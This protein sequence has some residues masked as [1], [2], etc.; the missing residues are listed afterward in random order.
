MRIARV[1]T[2]ELLA[3]GLVALFALKVERAKFGGCY[4]VRHLMQLHRIVA[5]QLH[6]LFDVF[7]FQGLSTRLQRLQ[8]LLVKVDDRLA[9]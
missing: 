9:L 8:C 1:V 6:L 3:N 2:F 5:A 4:T 7:A